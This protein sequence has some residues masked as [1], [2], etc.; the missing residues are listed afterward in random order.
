MHT[1]NYTC[2]LAA[3]ATVLNNMR[4]KATEQELMNLAGTDENGTTMY[5]LAEAAKAEGLNAVL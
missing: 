3:L 4:I 1:I 2:G 5:G